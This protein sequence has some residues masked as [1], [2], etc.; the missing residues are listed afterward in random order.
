MPTPEHS[1]DAVFGYYSLGLF[2]DAWEEIESLPDAA[3][4]TDPVLELRLSILHKLGKWETAR[5]LA[6]S[7]AIKSPENPNWWILWAY[8]IRREKNV[9][10]AQGVLWQAVQ[11][12]PVCAP[13]VYN[14][15]C[16]ACVL[17]QRED[18]RG[19]LARAI[20]LDPDFKATALDDPDLEPIFGADSP[21]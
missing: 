14:L 19:L 2:E 21:G 7:L 18:A 8:S 5:I 11:I 6:E 13:I 4:I 12:H 20:A 15:A 17:G 3:R 9:R 10:E 16:Y 1:L